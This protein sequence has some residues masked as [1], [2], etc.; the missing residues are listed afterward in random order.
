MPLE[1][2]K[3]QLSPESIPFVTEMRAL[4]V[5]PVDT[6]LLDGT[7]GTV[8]AVLTRKRGETELHLVADL[9]V[10][11]QQGI[12]N[13]VA[14]KIVLTHIRHFRQLGDKKPWP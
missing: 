10:D 11:I 5:V 1:V 14:K 7:D 8:K 9:A 13:P 3:A 2:A 6:P 12:S 4:L